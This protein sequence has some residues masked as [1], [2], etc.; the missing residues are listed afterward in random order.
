[1]RGDG[2]AADSSSS[3]W[4]AASMARS[5]DGCPCGYSVMTREGLRDA[6]QEASRIAHRAWTN[7][8]W[9]S[10][11]SR[12]ASREAPASVPRPIVGPALG[13]RSHGRYAVPASAPP[14]LAVRAASARHR[15]AAA[16]RPAPA[17][18]RAAKRA[19][20][21][22]AYSSVTATSRARLA[23]RAARLDGHSCWTAVRPRRRVLMS[24]SWSA[25]LSA[26]SRS[27]G[28]VNP[29]WMAS[30]RTRR[31]R[32][33]PSAWPRH[34][35]DARDVAAARACCGRRTSARLRVGPR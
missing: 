17:D 30:S 1:M 33:R 8:A 25:R 34:P 10:S 15:R 26:R 27:A 14:V 22:H 21:Q 9:W 32:D 16:M 6:V 13:Q 12:D 31:C 18:R 28:R 20:G 5:R 19:N 2:L 23:T 7:A 29:S 11:G 4:N 35:P 3:S 24:R